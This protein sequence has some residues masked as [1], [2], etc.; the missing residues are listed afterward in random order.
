MRRHAGQILDGAEVGEEL[1]LLAQG[2]V[3]AFESAADGSGDGPLER[4]LVALDGFVE[5][6][7]NVFAVNFESL[8]AGGVA[9]PLEFDA[10]G[11]K[12][13]DYGLRDF[14]ADAVAGDES[15]FVRLILELSVV[16]RQFSARARVARLLPTDP[17]SS[18]VPMSKDV[19]VL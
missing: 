2:D 13:A 1:E 7:G 15:Y 11:F 6:G 18:T 19:K 12:D 5:R 3:D 17:T 4:D 14:R 8:G 16:S 9:L 10:G